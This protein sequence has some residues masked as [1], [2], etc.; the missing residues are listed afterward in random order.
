MSSV[1]SSAAS[2]AAPIEPPVRRFLRATE[3]DT[4]MIGMVAALLLIWIGF[5]VYGAVF[6]GG[7]VFISPRNL[8]NLLVQTSSIAVMTSGMV[9]VIVMRHIDLSVGSVLGFTGMIIG[10][11]QV[12]FLPQFLG[13]GHPMIWILTVII[14][15]AFLPKHLNGKRVEAIPRVQPLLAH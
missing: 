6:N 13:L 15:I 5:H 12:Y 2:S 7:G 3:I 11:T 4:R 8:W 14:G 1:A 10:V 9:L